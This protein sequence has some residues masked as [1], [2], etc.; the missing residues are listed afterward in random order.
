M[1]KKKASGKITQHKQRPGKRLGLKIYG[2]QKI[3]KGQII[4]KQRGTLYFSGKGV[5][6]GRDHTL[7]GLKDGIVKYK[8][9]L[10]KIIIS[11]E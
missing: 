9:K 7:F 11:V 1:A 3:K 10:G 6:M 5:G 8:H 2:D 4:V